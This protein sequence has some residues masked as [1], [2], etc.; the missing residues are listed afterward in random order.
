[1]NE[2]S[3]ID[4]LEELS[5]SQCVEAYIGPKATVD[6]LVLH[7]MSTIRYKPRPFSEGVVTNHLHGNNF[8]FEEDLPQLDKPNYTPWRRDQSDVIASPST[9]PQRHSSRFPPDK[10]DLGSLYPQFGSRA[11]IA[12]CRSAQ[13]C[14]TSIFYSGLKLRAQDTVSKT[15]NM[16][17]HASL[18]NKSNA[19]IWDEGICGIQ[20]YTTASSCVPDYFSSSVFVLLQT[21]QKANFCVAVKDLA[22]ILFRDTFVGIAHERV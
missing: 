18:L 1:M 11:R 9:P 6:A 10:N 5:G 8:K 17:S 13:P 16:S 12:K 7:Q 2:V 15:I 14:S 21:I 19:D 4:P 20:F 22:N 3:C